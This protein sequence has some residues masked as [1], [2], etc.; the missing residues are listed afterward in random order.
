MRRALFALVALAVFALPA[1]TQAK[2]VSR[3]GVT[4]ISCVVNSN[5]SNLTNGINVVYYNTHD[6]PATEVD[7][8]VN[9]LGKRFILIDKGSFTRGAQIN[10]NLANALTGQSWD[11]PKPK[12]CRVERVY[13]ANGRSF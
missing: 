3:F 1:T 7:F 2:I 12:L 9:Y 11:G 8:L 10:H 6:S 4:I 13:L 5:G